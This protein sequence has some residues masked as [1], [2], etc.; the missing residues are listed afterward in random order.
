MRLYVARANTIVSPPMQIV[1]YQITDFL[2]INKSL[3][4]GSNNTDFTIPYTTHQ[5]IIF[6]QDGA[7]GLNTTFHYHVLKAVNIRVL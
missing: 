4:N 3:T 7:A 5:I 6:I 1:D 2:L